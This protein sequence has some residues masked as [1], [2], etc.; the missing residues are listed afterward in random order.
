MNDIQHIKSQDNY[1]ARLNLHSSSSSSYINLNM[2]MMSLEMSRKI[3]EK[4]F[5]VFRT[6]LLTRQPS[7]TNQSPIFKKDTLETLNI[8]PHMITESPR[9]KTKRNYPPGSVAY[10]PNTIAI[11]NKPNYVFG[12]KSSLPNLHL[13][14]NNQIK[15][16]R[17]SHFEYLERNPRKS[18]KRIGGTPLRAI[19]VKLSLKTRFRSS[20]SPPNMNK[21]FTTQ[22]N[23]F[24][25]KP[26][27]SVR[28]ITNIG[29][30]LQNIRTSFQDEKVI[31]LYHELPDSFKGDSIGFREYKT[32]LVALKKD[33]DQPKFKTAH[34]KN[35]E[36]ISLLKIHDNDYIVDP[37]KARIL[38]SFRRRFINENHARSGSGLMYQ[39]G[40]PASLS[41][42]KI[43]NQKVK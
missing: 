16:I 5:H 26:L 9:I 15:A 10:E 35:E 21:N 22:K 25:T 29:S 41:N 23:F 38:S 24:K 43:S 18:V 17:K 36:D 3:Q 7:P 4:N 6:Q 19:E 12:K 34:L 27:G 2:K 32:A 20:P 28:K 30:F 42:V 8:N 33:T 40:I 14:P 39:I 31:K 13:R 1:I 11:A 37:A